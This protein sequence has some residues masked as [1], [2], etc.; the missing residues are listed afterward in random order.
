MDILRQTYQEIGSEFW[1]IPIGVE[2][3]HLFSE[4]TKWFL[5]GRTALRYILKNIKKTHLCRTASLP[6]WCCDSMIRPFLEEGY[7][8]SFYSVYWKHNELHMDIKDSIQSDVTLLM[9][10][11]GFIREYNID[12]KSCGIIIRDVTHSLFSMKDKTADYYFGSLRKWAGFYTGGFAWSDK[13]W[14]ECVIG[15]LDERYVN[16]RKMA[17]EAK[18]DYINQR[19]MDKSYLSAFRK[20]EEYLE[21]SKDICPAS[22][23]DMSFARYIDVSLVRKK[24]RENAQI[25]LDNLEEYII[26]KDIQAEECPMFVPILVENRDDLRNY[27]IAHDIYCPV[28]WPISEC[29]K[30]TEKERYIYEHELSLVCDQRYHSEAMIRMIETIQKFKTM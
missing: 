8:V 12:K 4:R 18:F 14:M 24:R 20:A 3:N 15:E 29:H 1:D 25:L 19:S 21:Q 27:L 23:E 28:H 2:Q 13:E 26:F 6:S 11:F 30:L 10:Y 16:M 5:S 7:Q 22:Y 9:D 17:M